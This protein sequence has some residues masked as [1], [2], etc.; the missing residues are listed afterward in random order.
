MR[1]PVFSLKRQ[2]FTLIEASAGTTIAIMV[3]GIAIGGLMFALKNTN[4]SD[5]QSEL[6]I[7]VRL[8]MERLKNDLRLSSLDEIF[9][10]PAGAGPYTAL[11]FPLA[12]DSDG[13][14]LYELNEDGSIIWDKTVIYHIWPS[15]PHQLRVTTFTHRNNSLTD[16]QRQAQLDH[17][18]QTGEGIGTYNGENASTRPL[19]RNL[20]D[21]SIRPCQGVV[22]TYSPT[23][24][25][26]STSLGFALLGN[27]NHTFT[28]QVEGR[29]SSSTG[30][31]IGLDQITVSP[32]Y[33]ARE[34]E[35]QLPATAQEG[36]TPEAQYITGGSW[37]G[38][39]QLY[40]PATAI[41]N[42]FTLTMSN[43]RW[44]ETN[45]GSLGYEADNT[46][47]FFDENSSPKDFVIK[48]KGNEIAWEA[49]LQTESSASAVETN[50]IPPDSWIAVHLNGSELLTNG[51]W[52]ACNGSH[53]K[54]TFQAATNGNLKVYDAFIGKTPSTEKTTFWFDWGS[55]KPAHFSGSSASPILLPGQSVTSDWINLEINKNSNYMVIFKTSGSTGNNH[56]AA[57]KNNRTAIPDCY[58]NN[59]P[60]DSIYGLA[61]MTASYPQYGTYTSQIFDTRLSQPVYGTISWNADI[62]QGTLLTTKIRTGDQ[63]DLSDA[64]GWSEISASQLSPC[65]IR[66]SYRRYVQFQ[67]QLY[68]DSTGI[69][70][71]A[72]KDLTIDWTGEM[73]LVNISATLTKGPDYGIM[74][75]LVDGTP[76]QSALSIDLMIYKDIPSLNSKTKRVTSSLIT[77]IRPRNTGK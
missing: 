9:Y 65:S 61:S 76:L 19:F 56:P 47:I 14:G 75:V 6:D 25:R 28:F 60:S 5:I 21:W 68:S 30:Y 69:N 58:V 10:Y 67:A 31:Q 37:K 42:S 64:T 52:I 57:W 39:H 44:E 59:A 7:D 34:A 66:A 33:A 11:S 20:L 49:A 40:F 53:C 54:L 4:E 12:E 26:E 74:K 27:G 55:C 29:N 32:S 77:E 46:E 22:D 45:F 16:T 18:V 70:T 41:G 38:N 36:A 50:T 1:S 43:D 23:I 2:G 3:L 51:N 72:L 63:P 24:Q 73:Q 17:V 8:S 48:L 15:S 71:P 35:A 13:D 62:P